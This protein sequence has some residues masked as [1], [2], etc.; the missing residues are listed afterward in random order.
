MPTRIEGTSVE[1]FGISYIEAAS[2]GIPSIAGKDGGAPDA[3]QDNKTGLLC[4]GFDHSE[5]YDALKNIIQ[6]KK[7]LELGKNA[8][9]F[10][11]KFYWKEIIKKYENLLNL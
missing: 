1:G 5:I 9:E 11:K 4:N 6:N 7:Y 8:K 3:V 2:Y 10:S